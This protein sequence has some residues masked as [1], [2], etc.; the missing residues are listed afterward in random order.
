[1]VDPLEVAAAIGA[2]V[3]GAAIL[4][5]ALILM[6]VWLTRSEKKHTAEVAAGWKSVSRMYSLNSLQISNPFQM[7]GV[8][9]GHPIEL[10]ARYGRRS[11]P[12]YTQV[13]LK[14]DFQADV[15]F[16]VRQVRMMGVAYAPVGDNELDQRYYFLS[17]PPELAKFITADTNIKRLLLQ[18]KISQL[19]LTP[20]EVVCSVKEVYSDVEKLKALIELTSEIANT[21]QGEI[22]RSIPL[23]TPRRESE[24]AEMALSAPPIRIKSRYLITGLAFMGLCALVAL[25]AGFILAARPALVEIFGW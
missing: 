16:Q 15:Y 2:V 7:K 21:V 17:R 18:E 8:H 25:C 13:T 9:Q 5:A 24:Y 10:Y 20:H 23:E 3:C 6:A 11:D 12:S 22:G 1:M 19:T 14:L 4:T